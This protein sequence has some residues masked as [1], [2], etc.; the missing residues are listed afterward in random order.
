MSPLRTLFLSSSALDGGAGWSMYYLI[1][2][3]DRSRVDPIV[4][5]PEDGLFGKRYRAAGVPVIAPTRL[6]QR[7]SRMRF[8][9]SNR[10]TAAAS[11]AWNTWDAARFVPELAAIMRDRRVDL[12]Y[13]NNMNV[14]TVGAFAARPSRTPTVFHVRNVHEHPAKVLLY[15][16]TLGR[17][18]HVKRIIA[19]SERAAAPYRRY[20]AEK[21]TVVNNG[22]DLTLF[23]PARVPR[24]RLR[25]E[26]G[27]PP[28]AVVVGYTGQ[29]IPRKG[30]DLLVRAMAQL[31]A[32]RPALHF[33]ALGLAPIGSATD[34]VA[35]Y[36]ALAAQLGVA[37]R[38]HFAGFRDD[39]RH[40]VV[41]FDLLAL[42]AW[43]DPFPRSVIEALAL[44]TPVVASAVGG[45]PEII[46]HG[47][48]GLL[49]RP[50]DVGGLA[51]ALA[52]LID[53]RA[54]R[55]ELGRAGRARALERCD[56]A[57]LTRR[58]EDL[59]CEAARA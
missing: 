26:L 33:V 57:A 9:T 17:M 56:I 39:I 41:D 49:V 55:A 3:L 7:T 4:V 20:A 22:V 43:Q 27:L 53:D 59:L 25:G 35:E 28:D 8:S 34:Y 51:D 18:P 48:H 30:I 44:G 15:G 47:V 37:D 24:G 19:V 12:L 58:I 13:C 54:L 40:A 23:D 6:P 50:G 16:R 10:L 36:S 11:Y 5:L 31:M 14:K 42:P 52:R 2:H 29:I 38:V 46:D 45:I 32:D 1:A 21:V